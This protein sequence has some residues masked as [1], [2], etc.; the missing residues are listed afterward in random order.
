MKPTLPEELENKKILIADDQG[1]I[2]SVLK[3]VLQERGF[4][5]IAC[6]MDGAEALQLL[7]SDAFDL[8]V[9]DWQMPKFSG[10][11]ILLQ[12]RDCEATATLPFIMVTSSSETK[13]V[14]AAL[15]NGVSD[16]LIKPF[17]PAQLTKKTMLLLVKSKHQPAVLTLNIGNLED[18]ISKAGTSDTSVVAEAE[19][20]EKEAD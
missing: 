10:L 18:A 7:R 5:K 16:Y 6:A 1:S 9:C 12:V 14:K 17:Q 2:R 8:V 19:P 4:K 3:M 15:E 13:K 11:D 20:Q